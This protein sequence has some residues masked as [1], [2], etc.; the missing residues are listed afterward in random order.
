MVLVTVTG[1]RWGCQGGLR[2]HFQGRGPGC[3]GSC[4]RKRKAC[5]RVP[6]RGSNTRKFHTGFPSPGRHLPGSAGAS[7]R[8]PRA[9]RRADVTAAGIKARR[10][11]AHFLSAGAA[12]WERDG[13]GE[14]GREAAAAGPAGG[15]VG[16][17]R[18]QRLPGAS[19]AFPGGFRVRGGR[20]GPRRAGCSEPHWP[21]GGAPAAM[22]VPPWVG[23]FV[24]G[25]EFF[26]VLAKGPKIQKVNL[27]VLP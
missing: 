2:G 27:E 4:G 8:A 25:E 9:S 24:N 19:G 6:S 10:G 15:A 5:G 26:N 21:G 7:R 13:A 1:A 14:S 17:V 22:C 12:R 3:C 18:S 20:V 23:K 16:R 11:P